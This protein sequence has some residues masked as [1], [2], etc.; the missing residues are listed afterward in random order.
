MAHAERMVLT[1]N[2]PARL[3][4][5]C[6]DP[7][8]VR[9]IGRLL[10][11]LKNGKRIYS[12]DGGSLV[13][14]ALSAMLV[15]M[16][17]FGIME[18]CMALYSYHFVSEAAREATRYAIVRGSACD[19]FSTACPA[20]ASDIQAYVGGL[21]YPGI[22]ASN[23]T[24]TTTWPTTGASCTPSSNPC[25]N[26]GN[27]VQVEVQYKFPLSIPFVPASKLTM[28]STSQMVISQ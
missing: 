22:N 21:G 4:A 3:S 17:F 9:S 20:L 8:A 12:D 1:D 13:E 2:R 28:S 24:I 7:W 25:N 15:M 18:I 26:P 11:K 6:A 5:R 14:T 19:S 27:L 10:V 23:I 16:I